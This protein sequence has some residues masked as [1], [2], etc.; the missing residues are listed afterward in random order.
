MKY[1]ALLLAGTAAISL[2][3]TAANAAHVDVTWTGS[4]YGNDGFGVFGAPTYYNGVSYTATYR[5][6]LGV[7]FSTN[8]TNGSEQV[9]GGFWMGQPSPLVSASLTINNVTFQADG[10]YY[11][12]FFR[13]SGQG[14]SQINTL[15]QR[16]IPGNPQPYGGELFQRVFRIGNV[17]G[18]PLG[19]PATFNFTSVDSPG[20]SFAYFQRDAQGNL[21]GPGTTDIQLIPGQLVI[22]AVGGGGA[23]PEPGAWALMISGFGLAGVA[24]RRRR[25]LAI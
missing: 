21:T 8:G 10:G 9:E 7:G 2:V 1:S 11:S 25:A 18:L 16:L 6:D 22:A 14:A 3:A 5:F 17:Y 4:A 19:Q 24:L 15:A 20:G 13:Q 12:D 23:V